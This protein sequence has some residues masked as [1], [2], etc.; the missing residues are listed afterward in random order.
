MLSITDIQQRLNAEKINIS[1]R[2]VERVLKDAGFNK[3]ARRSYAERGI[4][5][6][7]GDRCLKPPGRSRL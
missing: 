3:L 7:G 4:T 1:S 5:K 6:K 2:T